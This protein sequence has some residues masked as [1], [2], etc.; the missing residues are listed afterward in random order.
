ME[1]QGRSFVICEQDIAP[2]AAQYREL[3]LCGEEWCA[4]L[5]RLHDDAPQVWSLGLMRFSSRLLRRRFSLMQDGRT[6]P[7]GVEEITKRLGDDRSWYR[8]DLAVQGVIG[9]AGFKEPHLHPGPARHLHHEMADRLAAVSPV[10]TFG[11][12]GSYSMSRY[13]FSFS[14]TNVLKVS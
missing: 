13:S 11:D 8:V 4:G 5:H 9:Q 1:T 14:L 6:A 12:S 2:T 10:R 3:L 7:D